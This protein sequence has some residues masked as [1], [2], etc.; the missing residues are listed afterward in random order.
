MIDIK[1]LTIEK[2]HESLLRG[3]FTCRELAEACLQTIEE[4]NKEFNA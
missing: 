4:K 3:E 1:K 2:A